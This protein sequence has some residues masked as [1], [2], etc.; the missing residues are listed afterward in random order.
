MAL[1]HVTDH[2]AREY[3]RILEQ[4]KGDEDF[5]LYFQVT[6]PQWQ[7]LEDAAWDVFRF[8]FLDAFGATLDQV[9][10]LLLEPRLGDDDATYKV[11]IRAKILVLRS[12]GG[13]QQIV[14]IFNLLIPGNTIVFDSYG[15][16][17]FV[18]NIGEIDTALLPIYV[19]F[20]HQA[21]GG[22]V[23]AHLRYIVGGDT[24][25]IHLD[26]GPGFDDGHFGDEVIV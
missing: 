14:E 13:P 23:D 18:L 1:E 26:T 5:K 7:A 3:A 24:N 22:G 12:S 11:R 21:A 9:G 16:A 2:Y 4:F 15:H 8:K 20:L 25:L 10:K 19:R 6:A 17:S